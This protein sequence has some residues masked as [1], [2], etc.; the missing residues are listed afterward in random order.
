[1]CPFEDPRGN[2]TGS[3]E[4]TGCRLDDY[5]VFNGWVGVQDNRQSFRQNLHLTGLRL[6]ASFFWNRFS[7]C[8]LYQALISQRGQEKWEVRL[9]T[10]SVPR[11][12][13]RGFKP[14]PASRPAFPLFYVK[15]GVGEGKVERTV[16]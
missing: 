2:W 13:L 9:S 12:C 10:Y 8:P 5:R 4:K 15:I 16:K 3:G 14:T 11:L 7:E 6:N 1:M